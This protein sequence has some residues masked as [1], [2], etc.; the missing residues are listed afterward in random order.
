MLMSAV[1]RFGGLEIDTAGMIVRQCGRETAL[2]TVEFRILEMLA[3]SPGRVFNREQILRAMGSETLES[4]P[5]AV[6]AFI[7]KIRAKIEIDPRDPTYLQTV[8]GVGYRFVR[9]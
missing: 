7:S 6:D 9:C 2:T 5:R 3:R 4:S 8:R 1:L